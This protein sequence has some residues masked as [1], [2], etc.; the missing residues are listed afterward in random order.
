MD[1]PA[2]SK[3]ASED[4]ASKEWRRAQMIENNAIEGVTRDPSLSAMV[5][6]MR[7]AGTST[8]AQIARLLQRHSRP[9]AAE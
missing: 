8:E 2:K 6:E 4:R 7:E 5:T 3:F 1:E 9:D